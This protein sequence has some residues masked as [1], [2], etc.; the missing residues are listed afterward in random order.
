MTKP[1]TAIVVGNFNVLHPGHIRLLKFAST[2]ADRLV[3]GVFSDKLAGESVDVHQE[4]RV[5]A[6]S[7]LNT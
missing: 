1:K 4:M 6:V 5:E 7:C 3:V 2:I